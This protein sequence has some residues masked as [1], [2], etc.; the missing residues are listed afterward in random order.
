MASS[1]LRGVR[2]DEWDAETGIPILV[3]DD[4]DLP[5]KTAMVFIDS[6]LRGA[7]ATYAALQANG[8][9][10]ALMTELVTLGTL[11]M[12]LLLFNDASYVV[13]E[14]YAHL[15][16]GI[17]LVTDS[18]GERLTWAISNALR[19]VCRAMAGSYAKKVY[20]SR[21]MAASPVAGDL[22]RVYS[23][24]HDFW[25]IPLYEGYGQ[26]H[27]SLAAHLRAALEGYG[28]A[29]ALV[30]GRDTEPVPLPELEATVGEEA[31]AANAATDNPY[32]LPPAV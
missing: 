1:P 28:V 21:G 15:T 6:V 20:I 8:R 10:A 3:Q 24:P 4:V 22:Q 31:A 23:G 32:N 30:D 27:A 29:V 2:T 26:T 14:T 12:K 16:Q 19:E 25:H 13:T 7:S 11:P 18:R 5:A 17:L 9:L